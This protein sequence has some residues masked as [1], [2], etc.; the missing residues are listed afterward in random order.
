MSDVRLPLGIRR[1]TVDRKI[2]RRSGWHRINRDKTWTFQG[3][4]AAIDLRAP[5]GGKLQL[6]G[7]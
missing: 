6:V 3:F 5:T 4:R 2:S 7:G 1:A